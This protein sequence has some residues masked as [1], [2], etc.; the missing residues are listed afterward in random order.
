MNK[1]I[2]SEMLALIKDARLTLKRIH[3]HIPYM[4]GK[5]W[6]QKL[7]EEGASE[8]TQRQYVDDAKLV[9]RDKPGAPDT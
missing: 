9:V 5:P 4:A 1:A 8:A 2:E 3:E 6:L 7:R